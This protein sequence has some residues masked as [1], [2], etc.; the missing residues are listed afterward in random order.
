MR[1]PSIPLFLT[2]VVSRS[3]LLPVVALHACCKRYFRC[4]KEMHP[5]WTDQD[6]LADL[7]WGANIAPPRAASGT[8]ALFSPFSSSYQPLTHLPC[9]P[10]WP[11]AIPHPDP[12]RRPLLINLCAS[13][14]FDATPYCL[15]DEPMPESELTLRNLEKL[16]GKIQAKLAKDAADEAKGTAPSV[17][18]AAPE[19]QREENSPAGKML[20]RDLASLTRGGRNMR[21]EGTRM[22]CSASRCIRTLSV[23]CLAT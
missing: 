2:F 11:L 1:L 20:E 18:A 22:Q 12:A 16:A 21:T 6:V 4:V 8:R 14:F 19:G 3:Q 13:F 10:V 23:V 9:T 7:P 17:D 5:G 15:L